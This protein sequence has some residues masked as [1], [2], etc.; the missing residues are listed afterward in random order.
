VIRAE[1]V[2]NTMRAYKNGSLI[3]TANDATW[4]SGQPGMGMWVR[5]PGTVL[6]NLAWESWT[7]GDI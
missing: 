6:A 3:L 7:A 2:G 4:A 1:I 5:D